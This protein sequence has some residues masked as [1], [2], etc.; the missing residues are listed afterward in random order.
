MPDTVERKEK[1]KKKKHISTCL[2][3][4][5][6]RGSINGKWLDPA[7]C[8]VWTAQFCTHLLHHL[9]FV[10]KPR[11]V[12]RDGQ[13]MVQYLGG[14]YGVRRRHIH[15]DSSCLQ[16]QHET[17]RRGF[18][19]WIHFSR[20]KASNSLFCSFEWE[21]PVSV[22]FFFLMHLCN[23]PKSLKEKRSTLNPGVSCINRKQKKMI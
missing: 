20:E 1:E 2:R 8:G 23:S 6:P 16:S 15:T 3:C 17:Q 4:P 7:A 9:I 14:M 11:V 19:A 10:I 12:L 21:M 5:S 13:S 22:I 18:R